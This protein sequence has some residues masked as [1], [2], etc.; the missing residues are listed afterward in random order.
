MSMK[1]EY[2]IT[3]DGGTT[4]T[5]VFLW[6]DGEM[7]ESYKEEVGVRDTAIHGNNNRLKATVKKGIETVIK[8]KEI[9]Y[10]D[11]K[12]IIASGMITSN[13]G[14]IELQHVTVPAGAYDLAQASHSVLLE[15]VCPIP[16][17]FIPGIKNF[18]EDINEENYEAM[19]IM[20]G[21][22]TES[23]YLINRYGKGNPMVLM[24]PGSH[25]KI[26]SVDKEGKIT[27]CMTSL[28]GELLSVITNHTIL[29]DALDKKYVDDEHYIKEY[30]LKGYR[31]AKKVGLSRACFSARVLNQFI[32]KDPWKIANYLLGAVLWDDIY[33]MRHTTAVSISKDTDIIIAGKYSMRQ[34]LADIMHD[35]GYY[36]NI[37]VYEEDGSIPMS[38]IG[39][40]LVAETV[41]L[42]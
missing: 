12:R 13:V 10:I 24:L 19:D 33:A 8:R 32:T 27:G 36:T 18:N 5:R 41:D 35:D 22:E 2:I 37:Q 7:L 38:A 17:L 23:V 20:R 29:A 4:N 25:A 34:A 31:N 28:S 3:I 11:I 6:K 42:L 15:D 40:R 14:L 39:T 9:N 26:V 16:I 1:N 21:E 30:V